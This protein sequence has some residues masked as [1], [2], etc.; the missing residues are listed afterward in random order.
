MSRACPVDAVRE[1]DCSVHSPLVGLSGRNARFEI[2]YAIIN[3]TAPLLSLPGRK[4]SFAALHM[5]HRAKLSVP[6]GRANRGG[7]VFVPDG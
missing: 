3:M 4:P 1:T 5:F 7:L 2:S 6:V